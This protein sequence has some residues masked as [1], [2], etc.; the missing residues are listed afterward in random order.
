MRR[1]LLTVAFI[2]IGI[3]AASQVRAETAVSI[4][5]S[6]V[7]RPAHVPQTLVSPAGVSLRFLA[8]QAIDGERV[9]AALW[10]P[11]DRVAA[12]TT[13][14]IAVHGSG[15][16][17]TAGAVGLISPQLS[18]RGFGVLGINTRQHD[19]RGNTD[20][21]LNI[22]RDIEAA[23][24][25][26]R[27]LGYRNLVLLGQSLGN[28]HVQYYAANNWDPDIKAVVLTGM[29]ANL[30][31]RTRYMLVA[32]EETFRRLSDAAFKALAEGT[33][34]DL[35]P[36]Q[37][38]RPGNVEESVTADHFLTYRIEA[39]STADGTYWIKR[40]PH[41]ILMVR[42]AGDALVQPFEPYMLLSAATSEG[43]LVPSIKYELLP[44]PR[45]PSAA[46]HSFQDNV[47]PLATTI[48]NWLRD[49]RL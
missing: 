47:E 48:Q 12:N 15:G 42:D 37:M 20:N 18:S 5:Y 21:F 23:V 14:I 26:A 40:I 13:L 32:D 45:A 39:S 43:S 30:P 27:A 9:D 8:I 34:R 49:Q 17:F 1:V 29:F 7:E 44:N 25:S 46:A 28:I 31:W 36:L 11:T 16:N 35:L 22:R 2:V 10:Q 33:E 41:P 24:Y 4:D 3:L 38:R 19:E 6:F